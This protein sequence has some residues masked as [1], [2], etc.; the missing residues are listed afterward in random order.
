M[1]VTAAVWA[2]AH[3][4]YGWQTVALMTVDGLLLGAARVATG[5]LWIPFAMHAVANG[6]SVMQ[7]VGR[8]PSEAA[9][10]TAQ[11]NL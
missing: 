5:S 11:Q 8:F 9:P 7:S 3:Y 1:T 10:P 6:L 4:R 2:A